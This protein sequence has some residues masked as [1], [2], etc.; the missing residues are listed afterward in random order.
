MSPARC[1]EQWPTMPEAA[2]RCVLPEGHA[3]QHKS[4]AYGEAV[5]FLYWEQ[6]AER[7]ANLHHTDCD[8]YQSWLAMQGPWPD[9]S[10][11]RVYECSCG[12]AD[13][14]ASGDYD[15]ADYHD[16]PVES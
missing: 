7:V 12:C 11:D 5:P 6:T 15:P 2:T 16:V 14:V 13:D 10:T 1:A 3:G 9:E 4:R 8:T